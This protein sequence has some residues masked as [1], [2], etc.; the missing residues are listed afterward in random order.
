MNSIQTNTHTH[1]VH[2]QRPSNPS[3]NHQNNVGISA[4]KMPKPAKCSAVSV[5]LNSWQTGGPCLQPTHN[6]VPRQSERA[7][8]PSEISFIRNSML[9]RATNSC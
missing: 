3:S 2:R 4:G 5:S 6:D 1:T 8:D 7:S 9:Q